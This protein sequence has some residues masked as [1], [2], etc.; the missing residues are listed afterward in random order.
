MQ[1]RSTD[2]SRTLPEFLSVALDPLRM[3][4]RRDRAL[5][6]ILTA[7][8]AL[9]ACSDA[10]RD[11]RPPMPAGPVPR[12]VRELFDKNDAA[13][14]VQL[15][16]RT[17]L[18]NLGRPFPIVVLRDR[19]GATRSTRDYL[20]KRTVLFVAGPCVATSDWLKLLERED[21]RIPE[22]EYDEL[23]F[24]VPLRARRAEVVPERLPLYDI[25]WPMPDYLSYCT[26]VTMYY[27][28]ARDGA[29]EGYRRNPNTPIRWR[30]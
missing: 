6:G 30:G 23:I 20:G 24:V 8:A 21:W 4:V 18:E 16:E 7:F 25:S 29:F 19:S 28:I 2:T 14:L 5:L 13:G 3:A 27:V 17:L 22:F 10:A 1:K 9:A 15:E 11:D 26:H 12:E